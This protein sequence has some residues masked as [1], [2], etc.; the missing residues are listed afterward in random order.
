MLQV[1]KQWDKIFNLSAAFIFAL[2]FYLLLLTILDYY[3]SLDY[4]D[5]L[6]GVLIKCKNYMT[7]KLKLWKLYGKTNRSAQSR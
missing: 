1:K 3:D 5:S 7:A 4:R 2:T 6:I